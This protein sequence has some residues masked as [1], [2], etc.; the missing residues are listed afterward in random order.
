MSSTISTRRIQHRDAQQR[1]RGRCSLPLFLGVHEYDLVRWLAGDEV[2]SVT[3]HSK[4]GLL[5]GDGYDVDDVSIAVLRLASG[6]LALVETSWI[7]P[8][9]QYA[10]YSGTQVFG[11]SGFISMRGSDDAITLGRELRTECVD[12]AFTPQ[13]YDSAGGALGYQLRRFLGNVR[14]RTTPAVTLEDGRAAVDV[15]LAV[16]ESAA[17]MKTIAL[18]GAPIGRP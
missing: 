15:A 18:G 9:G 5:T 7:L 4:R 17:A 11:S 16:E 12:V 8:D 6:A 13:H 1:L 10:S 2:V 14:E 3:A